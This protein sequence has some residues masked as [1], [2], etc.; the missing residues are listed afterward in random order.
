MACRDGRSGLV[1]LGF[2]ARPRFGAILI[3]LVLP[4]VYATA[5]GHHFTRGQYLTVAVAPAIVISVLGFVA[6]P[7]SLGRMADRPARRPPRRLCRRWV[8]L[9]ARA[10]RAFRDPVRRP[11]GRHPVPSNVCLERHAKGGL[12]ASALPGAAS[13]ARWLGLPGTSPTMETPR[14]GNSRGGPQGSGSGRLHDRL[15]GQTAPEPMCCLTV[16]ERGAQPTWRWR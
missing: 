8:R 2:G 6:C 15:C 12:G 7:W 16:A 5:E 14:P 10:S 3:G 4:A 13:E 11:Q 9:L 1:L